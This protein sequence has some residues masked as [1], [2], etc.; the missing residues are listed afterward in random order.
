MADEPN[1]FFSLLSSQIQFL[2]LFGVDIPVPKDDTTTEN[3]TKQS[4]IKTEPVFFDDHHHHE[5]DLLEDKQKM[6]VTVIH[7]CLRLGLVKIC[8][9]QSSDFV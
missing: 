1:K 8:P 3:P 5:E 4:L 6:P 7:P 2:H 9:T